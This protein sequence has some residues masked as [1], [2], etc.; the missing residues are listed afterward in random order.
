MGQAVG[1]RARHQVAVNGGLYG[2]M[3]R[4]VKLWVGSGVMTH[5]VS[6]VHNKCVDGPGYSS[7]RVAKSGHLQ[8][9]IVALLA[10]QPAINVHSG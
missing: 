10:A 9:K 8:R 3:S 7:V 1:C 2:L 6:A 4:A 5:E